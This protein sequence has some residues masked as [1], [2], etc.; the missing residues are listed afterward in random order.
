MVVIG[1]A[2]HHRRRVKT[3]RQDDDGEEG[4]L[5]MAGN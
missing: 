5:P 4:V 3:T 1:T 2:M